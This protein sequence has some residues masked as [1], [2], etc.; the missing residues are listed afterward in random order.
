MH[1]DTDAF[2]F[3]DPSL[4]IRAAHLIPAFN[5][6]QTQSLLPCANSV[7]R[8]SR[9]GESKEWDWV[10]YYVNIFVDRDMMIRQFGGGVGH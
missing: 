10:N 9:R 8:L 2:T 7:A 1:T 6:G 4:V 5:E 3:L